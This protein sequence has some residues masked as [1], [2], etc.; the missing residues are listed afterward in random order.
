MSIDPD[1]QVSVDAT[2][3]D[4]DEPWQVDYWSET[5]GVSEA[6]LRSAVDEVGP[7]PAEVRR[8]L[9]RETSLDPRYSA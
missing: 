5:F 9:A 2:R 3:V 1:S 8:H 6:Q 4:L 7:S